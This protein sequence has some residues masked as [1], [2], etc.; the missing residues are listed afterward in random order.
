MDLL[1][2]KL[3][4]GTWAFAVRSIVIQ[5]GNIYVKDDRGSTQQHTFRNG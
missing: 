5:S 4:S 2:D 3:I 1:W